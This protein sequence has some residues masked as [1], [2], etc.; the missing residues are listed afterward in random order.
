M[1]T[2]YFIKMSTLI[3]TN[4]KSLKLKLTL[5]KL[6]LQKICYTYRKIKLN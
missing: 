5:V 6:N 1:T 2:F 3:T 4:L